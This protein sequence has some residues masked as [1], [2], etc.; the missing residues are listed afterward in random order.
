MPPTLTRMGGGFYD[1]SV[2]MSAAEAGEKCRHALM[3]DAD[4]R[5][6]FRGMRTRPRRS[7]LEGGDARIESVRR[8]R[9]HP[10]KLHVRWSMPK[11]FSA[12]SCLASEFGNITS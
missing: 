4:G 8:F 3:R 5:P 1:L 6:A 9:I 12:C 10:P 7:S 11:N 2:A